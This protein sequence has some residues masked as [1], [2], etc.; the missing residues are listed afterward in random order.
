MTLPNLILHPLHVCLLLFRGI[1]MQSTLI[2]K[3]VRVDDA[4]IVDDEGNRCARDGEVIRSTSSSS[5]SRSP[6]ESES[7][8]WWRMVPDHPRR[9][10]SWIGDV[11]VS[12]GGRRGGQNLNL[13]FEPRDFVGEEIRRRNARNNLKPSRQS[14]AMVSAAIA[15]VGNQF[16][17]P[18]KNYNCYNIITRSADLIIIILL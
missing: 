4:F 10:L 12:R 15:R 16:K 8:S 17:R 13:V 3:F 2:C 14:S 7:R 9:H 11:W 6:I 5:S 1:C 18:S